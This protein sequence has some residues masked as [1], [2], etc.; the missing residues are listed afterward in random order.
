MFHNC[1][2]YSRGDKRMVSNTIIPEET[3]SKIKGC[4]IGL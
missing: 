4:I 2:Y 3:K 1:I